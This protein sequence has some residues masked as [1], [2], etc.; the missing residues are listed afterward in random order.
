MA[1]TCVRVFG[2]LTLLSLFIYGV[3]S[4]SIC[5]DANTQNRPE[6]VPDTDDCGSFFI[7]HNGQQF[8]FSCASKVGPTKVFDPKSRT[9]VQAGSIYDNSACK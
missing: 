4:D 6:I 9:C 1:L 3:M 5:G 8:R 7:C 2:V